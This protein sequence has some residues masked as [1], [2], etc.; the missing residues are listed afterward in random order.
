MT[1]LIRWALSLL[2]VGASAARAQ[3]ERGAIR[4]TVR[5]GEGRMLRGVQL[6]VKNT[7][8]RATTDSTGAYLLSGVWPGETQI[9][10]RRLGFEPGTATVTVKPGD[11][12]RA[13]LRLSVEIAALPAVETNAAAGSGRMAAFEQRRARGGAAF[14]TRADI[15]RRRPHV[16]SDML[17]SVAGVSV[18]PSSFATG[19]P[20][21]EMDRSARSVGSGACQVQ[22]FLDGHPYPR[23]NVDDFPPDNVEGI[24]I[25]RGGSELPAEFR[26]DNA[27]CG[28]IAIWT[29]DPSLIPRQP[30][31]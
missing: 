3:P 25:Y 19:L 11:T 29:R 24:E 7:D 9:Q 4:G 16:L 22:L 13:D 31:P 21:V 5:D 1:R 10:V 27:G 23:G 18:K 2:L 8:I 6:S 28:L 20:L 12:T 26:T 15:E 14:I 17:R 30:K